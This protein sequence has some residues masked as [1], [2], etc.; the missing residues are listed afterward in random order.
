M[1]ITVSETLKRLRHEKGN[2][3]E[4]LAAHLGISMQAVSKWERGEGFPDITLLPGIAF[5]YNVTADDLLGIGE[6]NKKK[7]IEEY[8]ERTVALNFTDDPSPRIFKKI[9]IWEE[10]YKEFPNDTEVAFMLMNFYFNRSRQ[11]HSLADDVIRLGEKI[12]QEIKNHPN[13]YQVIEMLCE[14]YAKRKNDMKKA[15]E[16]VG[17]LPRLEQMRT[18]PYILDG[19]EA[20]VSGQKYLEELM[21]QIFITVCN[22]DS[23]TYANGLYRDKRDR[24][25]SFRFLL[26]IYGLLYGDGVYPTQLQGVNDCFTKLAGFHAEEGEFD[27]AFGYLTQALDNCVKYKRY[28]DGGFKGPNESFLLNRVMYDDYPNANDYSYY[29]ESFIRALD[30]PSLDPILNDPRFIKLREKAESYIA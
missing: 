2:T 17:M 20:I 3:Q 16:Y 9:E 6:F 8:L 14:T 22:V 23:T 26:D 21:T 28:A 12:L 29:Y 30:G 15:M 13:R 19:E 11:K 1:E 24:M 18:M 10:A 25:R 4:E 7:R 27:E 5:Y